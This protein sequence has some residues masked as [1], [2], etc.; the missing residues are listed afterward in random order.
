MKRFPRLRLAS[1]G[2]VDRCQV[3]GVSPV[4]SDAAA[5]LIQKY[6]SV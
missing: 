2:I 3:S 1:D 6:A 5:S 4:P